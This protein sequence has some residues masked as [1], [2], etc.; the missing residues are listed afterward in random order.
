MQ[1][2]GGIRPNWRCLL[3]LCAQ[4]HTF[5]SRLLILIGLFTFQ[6]FCMHVAFAQQAGHYIGGVT[7]LENGTT[8]PPGFFATYW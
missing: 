5:R 7:G 3:N 1:A 6:H 8:A 2:S 4:G